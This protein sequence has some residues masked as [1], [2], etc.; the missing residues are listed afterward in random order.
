MLASTKNGRFDHPPLAAALVLLSHA[1]TTPLHGRYVWGRT[2]IGIALAAALPLWVL[3]SAPAYAAIRAD[4]TVDPQTAQSDLIGLVNSYRSANGVQPVAP[5]GALNNA[6]SWMAADMAA[7]NYIGH[8]SSDGRT[9]AQRMAAFG[10]PASSMYTGEDLGAGY[11]T[12]SAVFAGWRASA[13][14]NAV[15]LNPNYNAV[16]IGVVLNPNT[17]YRWYW[18]ADFGGP[19]GIVRVAVPPAPPQARAPAPVV[20]RAAP[21]A[22]AVETA[23]A[24]EPDPETLAAAVRAALLEQR[25]VK[26]TRHLLAVLARIGFI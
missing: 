8:V 5:N 9:P 10:Y 26:R 17:S 11:S 25:A 15:L 2:L 13:A 4:R 21:I 24:P 18:A 20:E 3:G 19:G 12:A 23:A 1:I 6:A 7:R 22:R 14:H 16:G